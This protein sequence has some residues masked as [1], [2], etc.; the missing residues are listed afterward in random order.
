MTINKFHI[1]ALILSAFSLPAGAHSIAFEEN[2]NDDYSVNFPIMLEL[3]HQTPTAQVKTLFLDGSGVARPWWALKDESSSPDRFMTSHSC[4]SPAGTSNDWLGS[5]AIEIPSEGYT[6]T[7]GAQSASLSGKTKLSDLHL[8]ITESPLSED[9]LPTEPAMLIKEVPVGES[10]E[11]VE[12]D[13]TEYS[14]NLDE[15]AGKTIYLNFANLN[16][17]KDLLAIDNILVRRLDNAEMT[18]SAPRYVQAGEYTVDVSITATSPEGLTKWSFD[19]IEEGIGG[20]TFEGESPLA[21]GETI[22]YPVT[23]K[24]GSDETINYRVVLNADDDA[25]IEVR[26]TVS[27]LAFIPWHNVLVEESTGL[28]CGNCPGAAY[29]MESMTAD[30]K[31]KEYVV[32]VSI[33]IAGSGND[34]MVN[35]N[36]SYLFGVTS[37]PAF[38]FNRSSQVTYLSLEHD[39]KFDPSN[40]RSLAGKVKGLHEEIS[41]LEVDMEAAFTDSERNRIECTVNV[42]PALTLDCSDY[43]IGI[44]LTENNVGLDQNPFWI[45]TNYYSGLPYESELGGWT[46]LP[47]AVLNARYHDV[48]REVWGYHGIDDSMPKTLACEE[49][50]SFTYAIDVPD[51]YQEIT[52]AGQTLVTSPAINPDYL[53]VIAYVYDRGTNTVVNSA[54]FPMTELTEQKF[55]ARD[56]VEQ[57]SVEFITGDVESAP[58]YYNLQGVRVENPSTGI[59]IVRRGNKTTKEIIR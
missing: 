24:V 35:E 47:E 1:S 12:G 27:G 16:T 11:I 20:L 9:N 50:H 59:Y 3:D 25:P 10:E 30:E 57:N 21:G 28:W 42:R 26:G 46:L 53:T 41:L 31:M 39:T 29:V 43:A 33:H 2:F 48:A 54:R 38:R 52:N 14:L 15:Y 18:I 37:A 44:V 36:Y 22:T 49:T 13:F 5:R 6:L 40:T 23:S 55:T 34:M 7:F 4:Y 58:V 8:F 32:P 17:D 45:Q 56:L 19:F 51:T